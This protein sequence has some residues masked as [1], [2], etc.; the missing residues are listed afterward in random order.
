MTSGDESRN[1]EI[2]G[3]GARRESAGLGSFLDD[4]EELR[5]EA[6][7]L[8]RSF[9]VRPRPTARFRGQD[10]TGSVRVAVGGDG[11]VT[12]VD[13]DRSWRTS[14]GEDGLSA[15]VLEAVTNAGMR[16]LA[17]WGKA[18]TERTADTGDPP[19]EAAPEAAA[20]RGRAGAQPAPPPPAADSAEA[21]EA[22]QE[23]LSMLE[24][25]E[26][27]LDD[28][29]SRISRRMSKQAVGRGPSN[30]VKVT[31]AAG[32]QVTGVDL[33]RRFL[34]RTEDRVISQELRSAFDAAYERA[35][36]LSLDSLLGDGQLAKL[37]ALGSDPAALLRK[38]GLGPR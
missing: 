24:G 20:Q 36:K 30:M 4:L 14:V 5:R 23:V 27:E 33:E 9:G 18:V 1:T 35:G 7:A 11:Q 37:H 19:E 26:R 25:A 6:E 2:G 10:G 34:Q 3:G 22:V 17:A 16:R 38:L 21:R 29:E 28:L 15:A 32:G 31:M 8:Q 13:L 12:D